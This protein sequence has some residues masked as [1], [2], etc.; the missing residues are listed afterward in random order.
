MLIVGERE[1]IMTRALLSALAF[2]ALLSTAAL[3]EEPAAPPAD[4]STVVAADQ[5]VAAGRVVLTDAQMNTVTAGQLDVLTGLLGTLLG[6]LG[7]PALPMLPG[8]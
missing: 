8:G 6:S 1:E 5:A 4:D 3:A 7:L 2:S